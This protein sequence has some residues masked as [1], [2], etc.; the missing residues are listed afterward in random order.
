M[1]GARQTIAVLVNFR[2]SNKKSPVLQQ[3]WKFLLSCL[4]GLR[5]LAKYVVGN[6]P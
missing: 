1:N 4:N 5:M 3:M 6:S 2:E